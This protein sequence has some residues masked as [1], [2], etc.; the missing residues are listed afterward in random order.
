MIRTLDAVGGFAYGLD[1][2]QEQAD[3]HGQDGDDNKEFEKREG[4]AKLARLTV[5]RAP[6]GPVK[7]SGASHGLAPSGP[8][9]S[10]VGHAEGNATSKVERMPPLAVRFVVL[11]ADE[12]QRADVHTLRGNVI[13]EAAQAGFAR[14]GA[15]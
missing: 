4:F 6:S 15:P 14:S 12:R 5:P 11:E 10:N 9:P 1:S 8:T 2:W 3:K 13:M 7:P